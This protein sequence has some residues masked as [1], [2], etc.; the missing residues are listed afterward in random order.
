[1]SD[2][3]KKQHDW[4]ALYDAEGNIYY[5]NS[6]TDET[7]WDEPEHFN[8]PEKDFEEIKAAEQEGKWEKHEDDDGKVFYYNTATEVTSWDKPDGYQEDEGEGKQKED[9]PEAGESSLPS[10]PVAGGADE[11]GEMPSSPV[12]E[13][14]GDD[15]EDKEKE[16]KEAGTGGDWERHKNEDGK[17][18]FYNAATEET[19][20]DPPEGFKEATAKDEDKDQ[21][22]KKD[23]NEKKGAWEKVT[24]DDGK[25]YYYNPVTEETAWDRPEGFE[26]SKDEDK[27]KEEKEDGKE[28]TKGTWEKVTDDDGKEYYY[29]SVTEETSWDR[30][31]GF[32][33]ATAKDED[34]KDGDDGK[35][36]DWEKLTD[37]EGREYYYNATKD[38]TQ[39][40]KPDDF[41]EDSSSSPKPDSQQKAG[42][43]GGQWDKYEDDEGRTY[44]YNA[45]SGETQWEAPEDYV[46]QDEKK[47]D[48]DDEFQGSPTRS[49]SPSAMSVDKEEKVKEEEPEP[50]IDPAVKRVMDAEEALNKPDSVLE[51]GCT[52]NVL[53]VVTSQEGNPT[54]AI[55]ALIDNFQGQTAI[56]GTI[57]T[58]LA[59]LRSVSSNNS[60]INEVIGTAS[61]SV[62]DSIRG[63]AQ[64]IVAQL[65]KERFSKKSGDSILNL[66]KSE[67]AFL[68]DMIESNRWRK[69]LIDLAASNKDSSLLM[70]C[71][72][73]ISKRGYHRELVKRMNPSEYFSVFNSMLQSELAVVGRTAI[74]ASDDNSIGLEELVNDLRRTC[75]ATAFTYLYSIEVLRHLVATA[76]KED[77]ATP[78]KEPSRFRRAIRKWERL[79]QDLDFAMVDPSTSSSTAGAS[80]LSRKRRLEVALT[81]S[82]LHQRPRRRLKPSPDQEEEVVVLVSDGDSDE[83][84]KKRIEAGLQ[85]FLRRFSVG[86]QVDDLVLDALLP[87]G[88]NTQASADAVGVML[89]TYP[90]AIRA[91]LSHMF[92]TGGTTK[93]PPSTKSKC[94]RLVALATLASEKKA[95][96]EIGE[97]ETPNEDSPD[98]VA[99]TRMLVQ[100]SQLCEEMALMASF[101]VTSTGKERGALVSPGQ[102]LC[103]LALKC[104]SVAQ[105]VMIWADDCI[106]QTDFTSSATY[107]TFSPSILTLV[108]I[109][110]LR[111][112]CTRLEAADIAFTFLKQNVAGDVPYK[113]LN[114]IKEQCLR[115]LIFLIVHGESPTILRTLTT[116]LGKG[117]IIKLDA[118]LMRYFISG[119]LEVVKP[120]MS[121]VFVRLL[122][123]VL[124]TPRC[125]EAVKSPYFK[126][127][128]QKR[129]KSILSNFTR[130]CS[131]SGTSGD[132][133]LVAFL[134]KTYRST[135]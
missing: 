48:E 9:E 15:G 61:H 3:E 73:A 13:P 126:E 79:S 127:A 113:K 12:G 118:S 74:S 88:L 84:E 17:E 19:T 106:R 71:I 11:E 47:A 14:G 131:S 30:P 25:E 111:H 35:K 90:L 21:E 31:E 81:V 55:T 92:R 80:V 23:G 6:V 7:S 77:A 107:P 100:G 91:L 124:K 96:V 4:S 102:H 36:G 46:D 101:V 33:E 114:Q 89:I 42:Q 20:W 1:M 134:I 44:Y 27:S 16:S 64:D 38:V 116:L 109:V 110:A 18:Y 51:P 29:N 98:E 70:Y 122:G 37:E 52:A 82:E 86:T 69:L 123:A 59:D 94:A 133:A 132:L 50:E 62:A 40:D 87:T 63:T 39:W 26:E 22:E 49:P 129:L 76:E 115:L 97:S 99:L 60:N 28:A 66:S 121:L 130:S 57:T 24:D 128:S 119:L 83:K 56:C 103:N 95:R 72:R 67:A 104:A 120:P 10:S 65:A 58:W 54:K 135:K 2:D 78:G 117:V 43:S 45:T 8:P 93:V 112:P 5:H 32:Q 125:I 68:E 105:G 34:K 85:N 41:V 108:R 75:T 53:E